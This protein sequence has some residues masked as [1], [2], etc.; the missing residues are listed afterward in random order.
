MKMGMSSLAAISHGQVSAQKL[1]VDADDVVFGEIQA[2]FQ[3]QTRCS[4]TTPC[5]KFNNRY[6][7]PL[8]RSAHVGGPLFL[9]AGSFDAEIAR[10]FRQNLRKSAENSGHVIMSGVAS[11]PVCLSPYANT[12]EEQCVRH[13][14]SLPRLQAS[15]LATLTQSAALSGRSVVRLSRR[16]QAAVQRQEPSS[17]ALLACSA[18]TRASASNNSFG[19]SWD[20]TSLTGHRSFRCG[21]LFCLQNPAPCRGRRT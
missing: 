20:R 17:V 21:G 6:P 3:S 4:S 13:L 2:I 5:L 7:S 19:P 9:C 10:T 12:G 16:P 18:T 15:R 14:S 8:K 1:A 11:C